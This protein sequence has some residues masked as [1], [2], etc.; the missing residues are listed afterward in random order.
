M[1]ASQ[2]RV[3]SMGI[4]HQK[5]Y[6]SEHLAFIEMRQYFVSLSENILDSYNEAN[7]ITVD[8]VMPDIE[9]D[10]DTAVPV[11]LI[12]NELLTNA[13][14]YAFPA[15]QLGRVLLS[16]E[17]LGAN[18]LQLRISD[19]GIGQ[20]LNSKP[21]GTGFGTQLV[22]LLTRQ[23][24]GTMQQDLTNGTTIFIQFQRK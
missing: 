1:Q 6:Q 14:K 12:V 20:V 13:L 16:L 18:M 11:G 15:G 8:C 7:R 19:N 21:Q 17:D 10:V 9:L 2:N 3:Q 23:L 24:E 22:A 4:L 5:L